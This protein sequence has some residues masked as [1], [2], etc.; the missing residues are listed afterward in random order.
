MKPSPSREF[1][2]KDS[3]PNISAFHRRI[4]IAETFVFTIIEGAAKLPQP[5]KLRLVTF[6][7]GRV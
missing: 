1:F 4:L 3:C 7:T 5:I 2:D 6:N